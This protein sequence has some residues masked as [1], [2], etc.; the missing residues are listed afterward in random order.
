MTNPPDASALAAE[1]A[2]LLASNRLHEA[3]ELYRQ[4]C[5]IQANDARPWISAGAISGELG[6]VDE[7]R[8]YLQRA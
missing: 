2:R 3:R 7:A 1:A 6:L 8:E 4:I 5:A